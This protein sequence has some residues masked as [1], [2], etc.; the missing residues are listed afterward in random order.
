[1]TSL[2]TMAATITTSPAERTFPSPCSGRNS[3]CGPLRAL[4][5][6]HCGQELN[7]TG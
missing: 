2:A 5:V 4:A 1:M 6:P 3:G 7:S